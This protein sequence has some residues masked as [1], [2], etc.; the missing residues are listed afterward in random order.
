VRYN[1]TGNSANI[2]KSLLEKTM[3]STVTASEFNAPIEDVLAHLPVSNTMDYR[4]GQV[5]YSADHPSKSIYLVS[6]GKV[7]MSRITEDGREVLLEI[8]RPDELFGE[9]AFLDDSRRSEKATALENAMLM[10]WAASHIEDLIMKRPRLAVALLQVF[11]QRNAEFTHRI[12]SFSIDNIERRLARSLIRF[13]ERLGTPEEDG[14]IRMM[15]FTHELLSRYV[16]TS[17]EVVTQYMNQ[18]RKQGYVSYSRHGIRLY[19]DA[20]KASI[21]SKMQNNGLAS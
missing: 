16:G 11:A 9:S 2:S 1:T 8:V 4:K 7:G 3:A 18:F 6:T 13:S 15:P 14:S 20:L 12:E 19:R 10:T 5:I 21:V 17:R